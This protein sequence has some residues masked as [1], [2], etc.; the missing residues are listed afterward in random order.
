MVRFLAHLIKIGFDL[1]C[2][3]QGACAEE[4]KNGEELKGCRYDG[5]EKCSHVEKVITSLSFCT[6]AYPSAADIRFNATTR[7]SSDLD[8]D[9]YSSAA[10]ART[11]N[12][13]RQQPRQDNAK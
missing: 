13:R 10:K 12:C 11:K 7:I 2:I 8:K 4:W 6:R 1:Y 5:L 3:G 9:D